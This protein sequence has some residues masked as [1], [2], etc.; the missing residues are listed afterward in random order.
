[1]DVIDFLVMS[2]KLGENCG[3]FDIPDGAGGVDGT[4]ADEVVHL[5][6]PIEG[7]QGG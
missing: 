5:G 7:G 4:C 6:V 2:Y 1:M 3:F